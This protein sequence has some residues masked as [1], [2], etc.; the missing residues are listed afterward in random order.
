MRTIAVIFIASIILAGCTY[1]NMIFKPANSRMIFKPANS[2]LSEFDYYVAKEECAKVNRSGGW[3][4]DCMK[5]R[6]WVCTSNCYDSSSETG[7]VEK[8]WKQVDPK[9]LAKKWTETIGAEKEKEWVFYAKSPDGLLFYYSPASLSVVDKQ[10]MYFRD[11]VKYP[12]DWTKD[13]SYVWR[14][15]RVN[16]ADK[17]FKLSYFVALDKAGN[18]TDP[19]MRETTWASLPE[20]SPLGTFAFKM[21]H[22]KITQLAEGDRGGVPS[23]TR[24]K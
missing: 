22:E 7:V 4:A 3:F 5:V 8:P 9:V 14:S 12:A 24:D 16:C 11:Q 15:V 2:S 21:C 17:M 6:G 18:T 1:S 10:Y 20:E 13:L 23:A 19:K